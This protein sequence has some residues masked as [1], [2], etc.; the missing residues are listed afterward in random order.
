MGIAMD[1][2]YTVA[3]LDRSNYSSKYIHLKVTAA[4]WKDVRKMFEEHYEVFDINLIE[5]EKVE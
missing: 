2:N 1:K 5:K 3:L 4:T